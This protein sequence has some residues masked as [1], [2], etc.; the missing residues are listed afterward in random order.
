VTTAT[1]STTPNPPEL[2]SWANFF[3]GPWQYFA[4]AIALISLVDVSKQLIKWAALIHLV[5]EKYAEWRTWL[6]SW[7]PIHFPPEWHNYIVLGCVVFSVSNVGYYRKTGSIFLVDALTKPAER[8][9]KFSISPSMGMDLLDILA[10]VV[11]L[12]C[13]CLTALWIVAIFG[14]G[15]IRLGYDVFLNNETV[16]TAF[17]F[18]W[19]RVFAEFASLALDWLLIGTLT[20][21][22]GILI[23]WRWILFIGFLFSALVGV[24]EIYI[25][26]HA[27]IAA[28]FAPG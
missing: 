10:Y 20:A 1:E 6:F 16:S 23:A 18:T 28:E 3:R 19:G 8:F 11:T 2:W 5:A 27:P 26:W 9:R 24:N 17:Q 14:G 21:S 4:T 15:A 13:T 12:L 25:H 22:S 7:S